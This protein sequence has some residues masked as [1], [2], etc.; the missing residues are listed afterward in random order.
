MSVNGEVR[1]RGGSEARSRTGTLASL[2]P[3]HK[4]AVGMK[5]T[6][7][8]LGGISYIIGVMIGQCDVTGEPVNFPDNF[9]VFL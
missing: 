8:L 5:K 7:G 3:S 2:T 1:S 9:Y 6:L 4:S